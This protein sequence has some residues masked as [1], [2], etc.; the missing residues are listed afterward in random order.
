MLRQPITGRLL[1]CLTAL[2]GASILLT[3]CAANPN[4][5]VRTQYVTAEVPQSLR[6]CRRAPSWAALEARARKQSRHA[7]QAEVAEFVA[8]MSASG[9]DCRVKL[10]AVNRLLSK[11]EARARRT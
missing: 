7:T 2:F 4:R 9:E 11:V 10:A 3:A 5:L 6:E 1:R 8:L